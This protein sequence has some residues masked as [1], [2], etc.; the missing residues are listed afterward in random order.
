MKRIF[1][2]VFVLVFT[3]SIA[4]CGGN[5]DSVTTAE[6]A[7]NMSE[8]VLRVGFGRAN[9]SPEE[10]VPMAGLGG[11]SERFMSGGVSEEL[12][13][14]CIAIQ[15]G[16]GETVLLCSL[17]LIKVVDTLF[18]PIRQ[19]ISART[20]VGVDNIMVTATHTHSAVDQ[21]NTKVESIVRYNKM[22]DERCVE[23]AEQAVKDLSVATASV[24]NVETVDLNFMRH[25][26]QEDGSI[27]GDGFG[28]WQESD[29]VDHVGP[30]DPT[31]YVVRFHRED[32]K[33]VVLVN[34]RAHAG[35]V[36]IGKLMVSSDF[37]DP[38]RV[39]LETSEDVLVGYYQGAAGDVNAN[40]RIKRE[41][42]AMNVQEHGYMLAQHALDCLKN[43]MKPIAIENISHEY[44]E[45]EG[46]VNHSKDHLLLEAKAVHAINEQLKEF[47]LVKPYAE[48]YGLRSGYEATAII[49]RAK[50][51]PTETVRLGVTT[52]GEDL[53]IVYHSG[54]MF[55]Q[56]G[57]QLEERS[58]YETTL[59]F[60]YTNG[61]NN[62]FPMESTWEYGSYE[63][64]TCRFVPGT[65]EQIRDL[66]AQKL[67][68]LK[69]EGVSE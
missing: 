21:T 30:V 13:F 62:Y 53:A 23:A 54:E 32:K 59:W 27:A 10:S 11:Y 49:M 37:V 35:M 2:L 12:Y 40:S 52:L 39:A 31:M 47:A 43:N 67:A 1:L 26:Y 68:A 51:G 42:R 24:G 29:A 7:G 14:T 55:N 50:M 33:D 25:Y 19:M 22:L 18:D 15:A 45:W 69:G 63:T 34:W 36:A 48:Q 66:F 17:D 9:I 28:E 4:A 58:A 5:T 46:E 57:V 16:E 3:L 44:I 6:A 60:S 20:G 64:D 56:V 41:W 61:S 8:G 65:S 38:F